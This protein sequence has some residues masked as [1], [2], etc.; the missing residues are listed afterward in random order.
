MVHQTVYF[1]RAVHDD[2]KENVWMGRWL[3]LMSH[4]YTVTSKQSQHIVQV[5]TSTRLK[6]SAVFIVKVSVLKR[7]TMSDYNMHETAL[8]KDL[9]ENIYQW[10]TTSRATN[11]Y[12]LL[13]HKVNIQN[14][15]SLKNIWDGDLR[16]P[17]LRPDQVGDQDKTWP[18]K[19]I[20]C[21]DQVFC[22]GQLGRGRWRAY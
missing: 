3:Q 12:L 5:W 2:R 6:F 22:L 1:W 7:R 10:L 21:G 20:L 4:C 14:V 16:A 15:V 18:D 9:P 17:H 11:I 19:S 8:G 13:H